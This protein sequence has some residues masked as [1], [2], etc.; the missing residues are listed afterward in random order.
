VLVSQRLPRNQEVR[1]IAFS[2][3]GRHLALGTYGEAR[4]ID[5][6][7]GETRGVLDGCAQHVVFSPDGRSVVTACS[8]QKDARVWDL[9][10]DTARP[11]V[12]GLHPSKLVAPPWGNLVLAIS[13]GTISVIDPARA[14]A[15]VIQG[16]HAKTAQVSA[17]G[18]VAAC[19]DTSV[20]SLYDPA[21]KLV[22]E[23]PLRRHSTVF[24]LGEQGK[25]LALHRAEGIVALD[26]PSGAEVMR[27]APCEGSRVLAM[28]WNGKEDQLVVACGGPQVTSPGRVVVL[29]P[30]GAV[31]RELKSTETSMLALE[32]HG[33]TVFVGELPNAQRDVVLD[34]A[35]GRELH[36][37][38]APSRRVG[39]RQLAQSLGRVLFACGTDLSCLTVIDGAAGAVG[40]RLRSVP[41]V[42]GPH[43]YDDRYYLV[44]ELDDRPQGE[45]SPD[46]TKLLIVQK[47][48]ESFEIVDRK[49]GERRKI[50]MPGAHVPDVKLEW[51]DHG[52]WVMAIREGGM[53]DR[54]VVR[55][56]DP[57]TGRE[58]KT[59][60]LD[61]EP[62]NASRLVWSRDDELV[63][64]LFPTSRCEG[65]RLVPKPPRCAGTRVFDPRTGRALFTAYPKASERSE[66]AWFTHDGKHLVVNDEVVDARTGRRRWSLPAGAK[67]SNWQIVDGLLV[68][69]RGQ[70]LLLDQA[71]GK[72]LRNLGTLGRILDATRDGAVLLSELDG[73][74]LSWN[75]SSWTKH[76]TRLPDVVAKRPIRLSADGARVRYLD[77]RTLVL[78]R[79]SDGRSLFRSLP[80]LDL[81]VTDEGVF[82]P[83][84]AASG[85]F[86]IRRGP[87]VIRSPMAPPSTLADR[88]GHP[89]LFADFVAGKPVS[90]K[91]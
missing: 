76:D 14:T 13:S 9:A 15:R 49:R 27:A 23:E 5:V 8:N 48:V 16:S 36:R 73:K 81:D 29:G 46:G 69:M 78:H 18:W 10:T 53:K 83:A 55:L 47:E 54:M 21:G 71:T 79:F 19:A 52:A 30:G 91:P 89:N 62:G 35:T 58:G 65:L 20:V 63:V 51:S 70:S 88:L 72:E 32:V 1:A 87:D 61:G 17:N 12:F 22:R 37:L 3:S 24:A 86:L 38:P 50:A 68:E 28:A 45:L 64:Q 75:T 4:V 43:R 2:P 41:A 6:A 11:V 66:S 80:G 39:S 44:E 31:E 60:L 25:R 57:S 77:G 7:T 82:D 67:V 59:L 85:A 74:I 42:S 90:P 56:F 33:E 34:L 84:Q 40:P 26:I